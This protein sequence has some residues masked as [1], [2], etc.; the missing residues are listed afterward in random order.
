MW[1]GN[2]YDNTKYHFEATS[3]VW[4]SY[5]GNDTLQACSGNDWFFGKTGNDYLY[6]MSGNDML[7]GQEG[8]EKF[9]H[10]AKGRSVHAQALDYVRSY[11]GIFF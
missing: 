5:K 7:C 8:N 10:L 2:P 11:D 3:V 9:P 1:E 6:G 4:S